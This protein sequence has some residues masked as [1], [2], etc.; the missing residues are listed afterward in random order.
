MFY[1]TIIIDLDDTLYN[2]KTCHLI[3]LKQ[4]FLN[5][6][7]KTNNLISI[8]EL[9]EIYKNINNK[10]KIELQGTSSS[11][12]K[13]I[14]FK[15]LLESIKINTNIND[16]IKNHEYLSLNYN[17]LLTINDL[18]WSVFYDNMVCNEGVKNFLEWNKQIGVKIGVLTDYETEYQ[19]IKLEKLGLIKYIDI[20]V[21]SEEVG[22]E[23][24]SVQMFQTIL[25]KLKADV[26][27]TIMIGDNFDKDIL[28]A[29]NLNMYSY[30]FQCGDKNHIENHIKEKNSLSYEE[31]NNFKYLHN[32]FENIHTELIKLKHISKYCGERFDLVQAGGGNTSIKVDNVMYIKASGYH[33]TQIN[34]RN[35]YVM[36]NNVKLQEDIN[37]NKV[38]DV[39]KYNIIGKKRGSIETYM[40]SILK[41]YTIHLHPIQINKILISKKC[42]EY[43]KIYFPNSL[44][45][46]YD[47]PGIKVCNKIKEVY[48]NEELIFLKNHGIILT[49]NNYE[50]IIPLLENTLNMFENILNINFDKYKFVNKI[51]EKVNINYEF[52]A[53]LCEDKIVNDYLIRK[54]ELF[55]EN[56]TF[57]DALIYCGIKI[58]FINELDEIK[59]Y[60]EKY[61]EYPKILVI[62]NLIYI[63]NV[64]LQKC[65]DTEDVLKG[66]LMVLD[67]EDMEKT[68]LKNEEICYLNNWDAEIYRK[69][70]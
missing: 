7:E 2:Y 36:I 17:Y 47:T 14:Y 40:H 20:V 65:K 59:D 68:Y 23:K 10:L 3:A 52:I 56:I 44:L 62:N 26:D 45:I 43:I 66:N 13:S 55:F 12:N 34:E 29:L 8:S 11:H 16:N 5:L 15:Q 37:N 35:G 41:K 42:N 53:Y 64:S 32:K 67:T 28:G 22:I 19:I 33:L 70:I 54:K 46:E 1:N 9:D 31:F 24:P 58:L 6:Q 39:N 21:T 51:S 61:G 25:Y 38:Q 4:V 30:W 18:Y 49:T 50:K 69:L 57:P 48:N 63:I 60:F 27:T